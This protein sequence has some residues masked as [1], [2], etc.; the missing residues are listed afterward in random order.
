M[1]TLNE[2]VLADDYPMIAGYMYVLFGHPHMCE[3]SMPVERYRQYM[4]SATR[5]GEK[6]WLTTAQKERVLMAALP[7][8]I[9]IRRCDMAG[10]GFFDPPK[11]DTSRKEELV[12]QIADKLAGANR[13][14]RRK[15][16]K[17]DRDLA[18][19]LRAAGK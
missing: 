16:S 11:S 8:Q 18:R 14:Q 2:E 17:V 15:L 6:V 10:R 9:E 1:A 5:R 3:Q 4:F 12:G 13:A 7:E 19:I